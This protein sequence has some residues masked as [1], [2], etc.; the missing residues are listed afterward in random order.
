[1]NLEMSKL[2]LRYCNGQYVWYVTDIKN[3]INTM[4]SNFCVMHY[5][6]GFY[7]SPNGYK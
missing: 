3:K 4:K 7:T 2:P 6:P 1:M 5:S